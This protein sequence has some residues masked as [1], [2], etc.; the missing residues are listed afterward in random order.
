MNPNLVKWPVND[1]RYHDTGEGGLFAYAVAAAA[2]TEL[3]HACSVDVRTHL[4]LPDV[5]VNAERD[6]FWDR[7]NEPYRTWET[8]FRARDYLLA[9]GREDFA[10]WVAHAKPTSEL[11]EPLWSA[12]FL[13][14]TG[15]SLC[16]DA[17]GGYFTVTADDLTPAGTRLFD[18]LSA[19]YG[20]GV[21]LLTF[22]DT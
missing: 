10:D 15:A 4:T 11:S 17:V 22:L 6:K 3:D 5:C 9:N 13:G 19:A 18:A 20:G 7:T 8:G 21:T 14:S 2:D 1:A 12:V 16:S